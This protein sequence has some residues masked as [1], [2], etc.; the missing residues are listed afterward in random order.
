MKPQEKYAELFA[1]EAREHLAE[2]GRALVALEEQPAERGALDAV[3]RSV[4]TIKGMAA[5]MGYEAVT[6]LSHSIESVLDE[7]RAGHRQVDRSV[8]DLL[9]QALD[10]LEQSVEATVKGSEP[11]DAAVMVEGLVQ[12]QLLGEMAPAAPAV[13]EE[14]A[15]VRAHR[16]ETFVR[17]ADANRVRVD[18]R[19]LDTLMNLIGELT[20]VRSRL[21]A[22]ADELGSEPLHDSVEQASRLIAEMQVNVVESRMAPVWQIFD[23]FPRLVR[24]TAR[25]L[26]KEVE[27]EISGR[28]LELDRSMLDAISD[29]LVHLLR[30]AVD[31]GIETPAERKKAGKPR[32]GR[33]EVSARRERSRVVIVVSDDG[34]GVDREEV[35]ARARREGLLDEDAEPTSQ[36]LFR[37]MARPGFSTSPRITTLSGRGV[38]LNVVEDTVRGL[39]GSVELQSEKG[40]GCTV[41]LELP[42]TLAIIRALIVKVAGQIYALPATFIRES[43]ELL[44]SAVEQTHGQEWISWRGERVAL[45]RLQVLLGGAGGNGKGAGGPEGW[46]LNLVA[47]EFGGTRLAVSVDDFVGE[48]E[49]VIKPFDLPVGAVP[50]FSGATVRPDGRPALVL[51]VGSLC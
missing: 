9:L 39:G 34:R 7:L 46:P 1:A 17:R 21:H 12:W 15:R 48:E 40:V 47:L 6:R 28:D 37:I 51:D 22:L 36:E 4:H 18:I 14:A 29:P 2:I 16:A 27:L 41:R 11:P 45:T 25:T 30:N 43:F 20:I 26:D 32:A 19:R 13:A 24:E 35:T 44:E 42:L 10:L 31:H 49:I 3:F 23:R 33:I 5:A 8:I 50:V 38:G